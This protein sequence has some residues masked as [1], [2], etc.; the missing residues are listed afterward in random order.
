MVSGTASPTR[1]RGLAAALF[2]VWLFVLLASSWALVRFPTAEPF[3]VEAVVLSFALL[4][5]Y[6]VWPVAP[7]VASIV[8]FGVLAAVIMYPREKAGEL[9]PALLVEVF[10]PVALAGVVI[11]HVRRRD[12]AVRRTHLLA[13]GNRRRAVARERLGRMTSHELRSPLTIATGYVDQLLVGEPSEDRRDDLRT[14]RDELA[15]LARVSERLLRAV[16]L[17]L[18][19]PEE[20]T[21]A[22][23][24]LE[25][26]RRRWD[27][28]V[29]RDLVVVSELRTVPIN[30]ERLR[31]ALDTLMENSVRYTR[32]GDRIC[33][34]SRAVGGYAEVG[35]TDAGS[36]LSE[37][38]IA[39]INSGQDL[40]HDGDESPE[41]A[42]AA[43]ERL[44]DMY[45]QTGFGL[46]LVSGIART[47]GGCLV[48][49]R[50]EH[51]GARVSMAIPLRS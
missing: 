24:L 34:F 5:G 37:E 38:L 1:R 2:A 19:A 20:P 23:V 50:S 35:V 44:R 9:P 46:R 42:E 11:F 15:R 29:D 26:V 14:V 49:T 48:A 13:E 22:R 12:E 47:A 28:V 41:G 39:R 36:G 17:D 33:L 21:D 4:Y 8:A 7:T 3:A 40:P 18:G 45:S 32:Q 6:A 16:T 51:G 31:A 10:A 27:V 30:A 43:S 25:E